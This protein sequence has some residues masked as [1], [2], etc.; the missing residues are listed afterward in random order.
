MPPGALFRT[1]VFRCRMKLLTHYIEHVLAFERLAGDEVNPKL[2]AQFQSQATA[3]R[4]LAVGRA[5]F[6][7]AHEPLR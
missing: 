3:Y 7:I 2:K 4:K 1:S 5:R 6:V